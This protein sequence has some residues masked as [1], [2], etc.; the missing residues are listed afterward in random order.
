VDGA[1]AK[2]T[3]RLTAG[4]EPV[5]VTLG[6]RW[7]LVPLAIFFGTRV[8]SAVVLLWL[9][10][11]Q[12]DPS[13]LP[14]APGR[15]GLESG[16]SYGALIAN[17]DGQWYRAIAEHGYPHHLP[18]LNGAVEVNAWAFY[19][20]YPAFVHLLMW[21]GLPFAV[22]A[23]GVSL[24]FG[25]GAM[26]LLYRMLAP[27]LGSFGSAMTILAMCVA[28][29]AVLWQASYTGSLALFF[30][31]AGLWGLRR[32]RYGILL[33]ACLALALT[34][35]IVLPL[36]AV[37]AMQWL[38]RWRRRKV[39]HFH[40]REAVWLGSVVVV[41]SLSFLLW[42]AVAAL[43]TG[44]IDAYSATQRAWLST[45]PGWPTW[46]ISAIDGST[47]A[48]TIVV[49]VAGAVLAFILLRKPARL[50]RPEMRGW[51]VMYALYILGSTRPATSII[52]YALL[53]VVPWWP[54]PEIG[55][56]VTSRRDRVALVA[57]V[58]MLGIGTQVVWIRWY[59]VVG[60]GA[61]SFP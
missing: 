51:A 20:L 39:E 50:W 21:P 34:R 10:R 53:A 57:L 13:T 17:W 31:L 47:P 12:F 23:S 1:A 58:T 3:A 24:A 8:L 46:L 30:I 48:L 27:D 11:T 9:G 2:D 37:A 40:R 18:L 25:G 42:P 43:V 33:A 26:C 55:R 61:L 41:G 32:R 45:T 44:R 54:F 28:P 15:P 22:A 59:W 4:D 5:D 49:I 29:A 7:D 16:R 35:P 60:P 36:A 52:R 19:P 6:S 56:Q 38:M 14:V